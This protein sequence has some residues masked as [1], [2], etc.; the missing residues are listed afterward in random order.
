M[1]RPPRGIEMVG[2]FLI[3][4]IRVKSLVGSGV[5]AG[6]LEIRQELLPAIALITNFIRP[7]L[8]CVN[9]WPCG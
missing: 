2:I 3:G 8:E 9:G 4:G 6:F 7:F 5:I 1:K